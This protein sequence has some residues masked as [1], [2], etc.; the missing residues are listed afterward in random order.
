MNLPPLR[1]SAYLVS[2]QPLFYL[3]LL[4]TSATVTYLSGTA[5]GILCRNPVIH[6]DHF[7]SRE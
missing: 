1:Y 4:P 2:L 5:Q 3:L 7:R 6:K